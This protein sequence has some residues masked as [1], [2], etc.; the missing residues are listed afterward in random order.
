ME[1]KRLGRTDLFVSRIGFGGLTI[2]GFHYG[3][4]KDEESITAVKNAIRLGIN[5]FDTADVYGFG[6]SERIISKGLGKNKK[7]AIIVTKVGVRWDKEKRR[8]FM[9]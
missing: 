7:N 4:T 2:G 5:F 6:R 8:A 1:Y 3:K 9:I